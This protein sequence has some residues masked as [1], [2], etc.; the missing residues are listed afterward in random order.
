MKIEL[1]IPADRIANLMTS[2][3]EGGDPVTTALKG[4]WCWGI[5]F[6]GWKVEPPAG[7]WYAEAPTYE[8]AGLRLEV[9]EVED[10]DNYHRGGANDDEHIQLNLDKGCFKVHQIGRKQLKDGLTQMAI[11]FP[12]QFGQIMRDDIDAPCADIFLQCTLFG[13]EKYA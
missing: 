7:T 2:A 10:E 5:Y 4:G 9:I 13:E 6:G 3:I 8:S 1:D 12:N 11:K